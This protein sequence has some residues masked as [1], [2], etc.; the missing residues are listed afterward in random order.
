MA[1]FSVQHFA[2]VKHSLLVMS[3]FFTRE[4]FGE[5]QFVAALLL[6]VFLAQCLWL[7][8]K[9]VGNLARADAGELFR[10][11]EGLRQW[12]GDG[13]AGSPY[14]PRS[15]VTSDSTPDYVTNAHGYDP[16][17]SPLYYLISSA[18]LLLWSGAPTVSS[19]GDWGWLA[20]APYLIFGLLVGGSLWYVSRRLYGNGGGYIA[21]ATYCFSPGIIRNA[22]LW[23]AEP[24]LG[25]AWGAFGAIFT[26]IAVA[27]TLYAPREVVL[28]NW[29]RIVLLALS[30]AL[31]I[32]C[33]F[34]LLVTV[35][36]ALVFMLY[37]AP[38]RKIAAIAI[39]AAACAVA[40]FLIFA[41]YSFRADAF[42]Q[43]LRHA[44]FLGFSW[45]A[46]RIAGAYRRVGADL[47]QISPALALAVPVALIV[48]LL[49]PRARYFGNTAPL[50]VTAFFLL[51]AVATPHYPG[52][53]F[54]FVAVPFLF[55]FVAGVFT[56]LVETRWRSLVMACIY[57]L[58][59][60][61]AIWT[62]LALAQVPRA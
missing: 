34:S 59:G 52:L 46:F 30:F 16:F 51:L 43:G 25:S 60:A 49:W 20:R 22:A 53:G 2:M 9:M 54:L 40:F 19:E 61:N 15:E 24:E 11:K 13:I 23:Y 6:L 14:A 58:L 55:V 3:G 44:S 31:A 50:L 42:W 12:Q 28:W 57:G 27:H 56:D 36:L 48:Y 4:R 39:W 32:G 1:E 35:P 37:L 33:Q 26:G 62:V 10:I 18:P 17:H 21:L 47:G 38:T 41:S 45:K 5:P 7:A 8:D 29:R